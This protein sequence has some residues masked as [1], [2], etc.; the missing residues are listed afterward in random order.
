MLHNIATTAT[1]LATGALA[2]VLGAAIA[3]CHDL[4]RVGVAAA[5]GA[6]ATLACIYLLA[7]VVSTEGG[8]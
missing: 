1:I 5:A 8:Q 4:Q 2:G 7:V 6:V 3:G